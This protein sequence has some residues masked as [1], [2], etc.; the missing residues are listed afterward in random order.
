MWAKDLDLPY[1][2]ATAPDSLNQKNVDFEVSGK[3]T[4]CDYL[5]RLVAAK[6]KLDR[7]DYDADFFR[8]RID[9]HHMIYTR[10][11]IHGPVR[12]FLLWYSH[13]KDI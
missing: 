9:F 3:E 10:L 6:P 8:I 2:K 7:V 1:A 11:C 5:N 12:Q 4:L 13:A